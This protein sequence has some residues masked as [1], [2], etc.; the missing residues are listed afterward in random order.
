MS[1]AKRDVERE[2]GLDKIGTT[3]DETDDCL[4]WAKEDKEYW[5]TLAL[6]AFVAFQKSLGTQLN[7]RELTLM[8]QKSL[9]REYQ[10]AWIEVAKAVKAL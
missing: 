9:V 4:A 3:K 2:L 1:I 7:S 10:R 8:W 6:A 5:E